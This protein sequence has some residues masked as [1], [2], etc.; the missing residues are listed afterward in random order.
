MHP[1]RGSEKI[2]VQ[3]CSAGRPRGLEMLRASACRNEAHL[4]QGADRAA[5]R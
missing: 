3:K 5:P 4:P 1:V 2:H